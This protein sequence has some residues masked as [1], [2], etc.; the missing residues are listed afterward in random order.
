MSY[1]T[2]PKCGSMT[3]EKGVICYQCQDKQKTDL[4]LVDLICGKPRPTTKKRKK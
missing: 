2:C 1:D 3:H 4:E